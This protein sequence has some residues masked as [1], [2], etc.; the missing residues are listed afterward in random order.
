M[1]QAIAKR[2]KQTGAHYTPELLAK[3]VATQIVN[4]WIGR[5]NNIKI[6][7]PAVGD[8]ELLLALIKQLHQKQF[9]S[10]EVSGFD[11]DQNAIFE[12]TRRINSKFP[13][14]NIN[15]KCQDFLSYILDNYNIFDLFNQSSET[16]YDLIISN[17]PYVRTQ[18]MGADR[19]Q[20]ISKQFGFSGRVD[21][22]FPFIKGIS[23]TLKNDGV[24][25][26][27]VSNRFMLTRSGADVR[28]FILNNFEV[29][30]I[31]DFGD[32]KLFEAAVLPA[33]LIVKPKKNIVQNDDV[34]FSTIYSTENQK[35]IKKS[36]SIVDALN[37]EGV[38][39]NFDGRL[40][41]VSH[42]A[43]D[44]G[45]KISGVWRISTDLSDNFIKVVRNNTYCTFN[46]LGK[47]RVG[48][49]TTA[50]K[51]FIKQNWESLPADQ[52]PE[53]ELLKNLTTHHIAQQYYSQNNE[54]KKIFYP[55]THIKG[56]RA[57][58]NLD[59]YP[60]ALNYLKNYKNDL[61]KRTYLIEAGRNWFELWVPQDPSL[62]EHPKIVFWDIAKEPMF[63]MDF[64]GSIVNGD[65][66]WLPCTNPHNMDLFWLALAIGNSTFIEDFYDH[67][68]NN[69]L[70]A[71]RRRFMT[72]YVKKFPLPNPKTENSIKII[73]L[74]KEIFNKK[75]D[76][77]I[78]KNRKK[79]NELIWQS[80]GFNI[81]KI[82]R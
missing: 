27:I 29:L 10:F 55:H 23:Q 39:E 41:N 71:G 43:L 35:P 57:V 44:N 8:G 61:E 11:T 38:V 36:V 70:Y 32:T 7:D 5:P 3:F 69:K 82:F 58:I 15:L 72:Q 20:E 19:A 45:K 75:S 13:S 48:V 46:D 65:C 2:R 68:F 33:V 30:H 56:K 77:I 21:L 66:Y 53:K 59:K 54:K 34:K 40:F 9:Y 26:I 22:Y 47:I 50:D 78:Y 1:K 79:I 18:V 6:F 73:Q 81:E 17:P 76:E 12:A 80:F 14:I 63:W 28:R 51:I 67:K 64:D 60:K 49:K 16:K 62:W 37:Y 25:G 42:G 74:T 4:S 24:A 31:W 52:I